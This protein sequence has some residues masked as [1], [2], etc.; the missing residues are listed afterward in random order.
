[1][2]ENEVIQIDVEGV[3]KEK[4]P[5]LAKRLPRVLINYLKRIVHQEEINRFMLNNKEKHDFEFMEEV[6]K[7]MNLKTEILGFENVPET[8]RFVFAANHPLGGL[9]SLVLML[10]VSQ[11]FPNLRFV[12]NDILMALKP[13]KGLFIPINKHGGQTR[14][15]VE[16]INSVYQSDFQL[17]YFPAGLVSRK[18]KGK[19]VDL[20]WQK[21]F[22]GKAVSSQRD[23]IPVFID[24]RNSRFFYNLAKFRKIFRIKANIEMLFL[25][26]EMMKQKGQ[27]IKLIF[28]KPIPFSTFD[29]SKTPQEWADYLKD[30]TYS[31]KK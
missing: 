22:V 24:G 16:Y 9:E 30:L 8:G 14:Q 11:K 3:L 26:D 28:G 5:K 6:K 20:Q 7:Y 1:M 25:A 13:M 12:V 27:T 18:I 21:S 4:S 17:L 10:A 19:I 23:I 15:G 31:L 2:S 29:K